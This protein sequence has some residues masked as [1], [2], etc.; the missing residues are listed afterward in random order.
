MSE[1]YKNIQP[2]R[3]DKT[4]VINLEKGK[5]PPQAIDLEEAILGAMI[6]DKKGV[7]DGMLVIKDSSIFYKDA[8]KYIFEAIQDLY[9][10]AQPIDML[11]VSSRL[12]SMGNLELV[13]G[14]FYLIQLTQKISSSAHLEYHCRI[15]MQKYIQRAMIR[16]CSEL[17]SKAYDEETDVFDL[18]DEANLKL[19]NLQE[20][21]NV[22]VQDMTIGEALDVIEKKVELLS[23]KDEDEISGI[24]TGFKKVDLITSGFQP[25]DLIVI[26]AR[27]GMGKTSLVMKTMLANAL[28]GVAGGFVSL[29]M[30]TVQLVTRMIACNSHFHLNQLFRTGFEHKKYFEQFATKKY[31]MQKYGVHFDDRSRELFDIVAK[32]RLW[33]RKFDIKYV[34]IDYLQIMSFKSLGKNGNREQEIS[35]ATRTLKAL[36]KELSIPVILLSQ[37]SRDV[38]SR[39]SSKRPQLKDLRESG[40]IEQD[41]DLVAFIYRPEYYGIEPDEELT[42]MGANTEFII[43]K[44][45]NGSLDIKGLYFDANKTKFMD[46]EDLESS[47]QHDA[48][49]NSSIVNNIPKINPNDAFGN[50]EDS[51]IAF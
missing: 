13:G 16:D 29:E 6:I 33:K 9:K 18:L 17:I 40:A 1:T 50:D 46:P 42:A 14:D 28:K 21:T 48:E 24:F 47:K 51:D 30:S 49:M 15:V 43:A 22:G 3:V 27:P 4:M 39:G 11:T 36:A 31:E 34:I 38:E 10:K 35:M 23:S 25:T 37:L 2:I 8:H 41:A 5:L 45:R 32:I 26:A 20:Q 44:H 7:E 12:K 19:T